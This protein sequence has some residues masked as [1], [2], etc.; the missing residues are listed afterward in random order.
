MNQLLKKT[1]FSKYGIVYVVLLGALA[2]C[3]TILHF[4]AVYWDA[5]AKEWYAASLSGLKDLCTE[6]EESFVSQK[7]E[8]FQYTLNGTQYATVHG[9]VPLDQGEYLTVSADISGT[10]GITVFLDLYADGY[11][12]PEQ[13]TGLSLTGQPTHVEQR[14]PLGK[15][16]PD[17]ALFRVFAFASSESAVDEMM[18][19]ENVRISVES[20]GS[21][22]APVHLTSLVI[23]IFF[24]ILFLIALIIY[25]SNREK[26]EFVIPNAEKGI[27]FGY[28]KLK[29]TPKLNRKAGAIVGQLIATNKGKPVRNLSSGDYP[30]NIGI[31]IVDENHVM[32]NQECGRL[33]TRKDG[34]LRKGEKV[35]L[36]VNLENLQ[37][38]SGKNYQLA[39]TV[40]Q[41]RVA[42][43]RSTAVYYPIP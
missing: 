34:I 5:P 17:V 35:M 18:V 3:I 31:S 16:H 15:V 11:D 22:F 13:E 8:I 6:G 28:L 27:V 38:Y 42:W 24:G 7:G 19:L 32:V 36:P 23:G 9:S 12:N 21:M 1:G 40:V 14:W 26:K 4:A 2:Y 29:L 41:E 39:F 43:D 10:S 20:N 25:L 30:V 37:E 33:A